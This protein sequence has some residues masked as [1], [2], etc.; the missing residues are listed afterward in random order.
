MALKRKITKAD[1]DKLAD[2]LKGEYKVSP[3]DANA[4]ILETDGD[5]DAAAAALRARD[6]EKD[7]A[8][9]LQKDLDAIKSAEQTAKDEAARAKGDVTA[10]EASWKAKL[11]EANANSRVAI[12]KLNTQIQGLTIDTEA[13][14]LAGR[15]SSAP[16]L[17]LP[18]IRPRLSLDMS[19]DT[20][21]VRVVDKFGKPSAASVGDLE[22]E[23]ASDK[24]FAPIILASKGSGGGA[25]R[26][27]N[28]AGGRPN[29]P[30]T[31]PDGTPKPLSRMTPSELA[32]HTRE[33][34]AERQ[35]AS[36]GS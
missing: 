34:I 9:K 22:K 24:A 7:R 19:G 20:P 6:A 21:I 15:I 18:H 35:A 25:P 3:S 5:E 36:E 13:R 27:P 33:K 1:F 32:A 17:L 11:D 8:N 29:H 14:A 30:P 2:V 28:P 12:E 31:N 23:L 16:E 26:N 10:L 4:Y